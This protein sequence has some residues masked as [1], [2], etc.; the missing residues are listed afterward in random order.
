MSSLTSEQSTVCI[1]FQGLE[2]KLKM[3]WFVKRANKPLEFMQ[4]DPAE[5]LAAFPGIQNIH[6]AILWKIESR[7]SRS[8]KDF[9]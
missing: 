5:W 8:F 4:S 9:T 1:P 2:Q 3:H 7:N 6:K